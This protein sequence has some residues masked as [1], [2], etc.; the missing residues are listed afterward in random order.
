MRNGGSTN[1]GQHG[2]VDRRWAGP[3]PGA[4]PQPPEGLREDVDRWKDRGAAVLH[5]V[6]DGEVAGAFALEGQ[7]RA[8]SR[9]AIVVALN[10][11]LP[12]RIDLALPDTA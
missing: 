10:A 7:V 12:R 4:G 2:Q 5:L 8:V 9:Q 11:Q 1:G 6:R 3:P